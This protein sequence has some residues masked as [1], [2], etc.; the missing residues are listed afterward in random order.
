MVSAVYDDTRPD[1]G[2]NVRHGDRH[3]WSPGLWRYIIERFAIRSALDVG[4]G[5]G[6]AVA[7]FQRLGV[8]AHG[9]EGLLSNVQRSVTPISLH[10]L[11]AGP[12]IMPV[13][14]VWCSEVAEHITPDKVDY[15]IQTLANGKLV[16]MTHALP[17][18]GGHNHVN[19][20][21]SEYW[22][23]KLNNAGYE[24]LSDNEF[25]RDLAKKEEVYTYFSTSGLVFAR[26]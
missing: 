14:F 15:L 25:F 18:Q 26:Q 5:E 3:T 12:F 2:G 10:D 7:Y 9:I 8:N 23:E 13:D 20:Q 4:C 11:L 19:C 6:H 1:L 17:G 24:L 21:P 22:I 16:A